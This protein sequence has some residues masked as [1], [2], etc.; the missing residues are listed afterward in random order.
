M[1]LRSERLYL[2]I[3][4]LEDAPLRHEWFNDPQFTR[5][6]LG[7]PTYITYKQIEEEVKF[8][9]LPASYTG[10]FELALLTSDNNRYIGNTF[11]RKINMADR[12]AEYGIF[13]GAQDLWGGHFGTEVTRIMVEY[14]FNEL[15]FNRIWLT[16]LSFNHRAISCFEKCGFKN[17][18][19]FRKAIFSGGTFND[20][21]SMS[22][23]EEEYIQK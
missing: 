8:A 2:R 3:P 10:M 22:I 16:V 13:I 21:Y 7:R 19:V 1:I 12:S 9:A 11:F 5:L 20:V 4:V 15:G 17:E 23:L 6:Y 18:G 14:G